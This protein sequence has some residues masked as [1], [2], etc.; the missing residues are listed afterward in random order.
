LGILV[1]DEWFELLWAFGEERMVVGVNASV[2]PLKFISC[3]GKR[4]TAA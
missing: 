3:K 2:N 4:E 1:H